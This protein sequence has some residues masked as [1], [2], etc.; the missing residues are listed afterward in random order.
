MRRPEW[1]RFRNG[2]S[3]ALESKFRR[4]GLAAITWVISLKGRRDKVFLMTK[5][6]THGR[7]KQVGMTIWKN[8]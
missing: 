1:V 8:S 4:W 6:C 5:V 3:A 7:D 2:R